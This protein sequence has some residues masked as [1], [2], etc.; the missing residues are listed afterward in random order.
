MADLLFISSIT[1]FHSFII[2]IILFFGFRRWFDTRY[3]QFLL[4]SLDFFGLFAWF[5]LVGLQLLLVTIDPNGLSINFL[6]TDIGIP[7]MK[8]TVTGELVSMR[9]ADVLGFAGFFSVTGFTIFL[10]LLVDSAHRTTYDPI[11]IIV[12]GIIAT[13]MVVFALLPGVE[14]LTVSIY[15]QYIQIGFWILRALLLLIYTGNLFMNSTKDLKTK[16]GI[17]MMGAITYLLAQ[18]MILTQLLPLN[19]GLVEVTYLL[20]S[21]FFMIAFIS[22]PRLLFILPFKTSQLVV[23]N[24]DTKKPLFSYSWTAQRD[25]HLD[26][27]YPGMIAVLDALSSGVHELHLEDAV[28]LINR[29]KGISCIIVTSDTSRAMKNSL[30]IFSRRFAALFDVLP[31]T[32]FSAEEYGAV[33]QI[34]HEIFPVVPLYSVI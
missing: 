18:I 23:I 30:D 3:R 7:L 12:Y 9:L 29:Q 16:A 34:V 1:L 22:E 31:K 27:F 10:V 6:M 19:I 5:F 11:K 24:T 2:L 14:A 13:L 4:L 15:L 20:G 26:V 33:N 21:F 17:A 8:T 25:Q 28:L 32:D